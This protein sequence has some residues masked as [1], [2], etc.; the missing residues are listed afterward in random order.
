[1]QKL[2]GAAANTPLPDDVGDPDVS[3]GDAQQ[4]GNVSHD[5]VG[6]EELRLGHGDPELEYSSV[7]KSIEWSVEEWNTLSTTTGWVLMSQVAGPRTIR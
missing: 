3:G 7:R 1:M 6:V 4:A 2:P 5:R